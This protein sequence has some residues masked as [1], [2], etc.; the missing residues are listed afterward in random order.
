MIGGLARKF[1]H[2]NAKE[3]G[4]GKQVLA[5]KGAEV[6]RCRLLITRESGGFDRPART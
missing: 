3:R 5:A 4:N 1:G 2:F 6:P